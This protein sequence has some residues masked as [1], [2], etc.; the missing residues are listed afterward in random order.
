[1]VCDF[2]FSITFYLTIINSR[3]KAHN[4]QFSNNKWKQEWTRNYYCYLTRGWDVLSIV[5]HIITG[6]IVIAHNINL[7]FAIFRVANAELFA[8]L[9]NDLGKVTGS[10]RTG[11][12]PESVL[13]N[14]IVPRVYCILSIHL[15]IWVGAA[16][17]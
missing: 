10:C 5:A 3:L 15:M 17:N 7:S 8:F 4:Y 13:L 12:P 6:W 16:C 1:V 14:F 11:L 9:P 2:H